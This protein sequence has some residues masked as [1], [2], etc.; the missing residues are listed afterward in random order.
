[1]VRLRRLRGLVAL[2]SALVVFVPSAPAH[3]AGGG[4]VVSITVNPLRLFIPLF[5]ASAEVRLMPALGLAGIGGL[6]SVKVHGARFTVKEVGGQVVVYPLG[7]FRSL[8]LGGEVLWLHVDGGNAD[9]SATAAGVG[10][11][12]FVGYK[13]ITRGGFTFSVQGGGQYV[14][15]QADASDSQGNSATA[16]ADGFGLLLNLNFGWSF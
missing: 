15:A 9:I 1:M 12:P 4:E 14:F 16:S 7:D 6:G 8:E 10:V 3:A 13:L 2:A 11:G 5:E